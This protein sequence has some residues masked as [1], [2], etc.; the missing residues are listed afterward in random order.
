MKPGWIYCFEY[1]GDI[2]FGVFCAIIRNHYIWRDTYFSGNECAPPMGTHHEEV[3]WTEPVMP[4]SASTSQSDMF[5]AIQKSY[6][7]K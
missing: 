4:Y 6:A 1:R 5:D 3:V 7:N 2:Y